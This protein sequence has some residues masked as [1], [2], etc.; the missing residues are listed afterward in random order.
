MNSTAVLRTETRGLS[1]RARQDESEPTPRIRIK[2][3]LF[4]RPPRLRLVSQNP[5]QPANGQSVGFAGSSA[6]TLAVPPTSDNRPRRFPVCPLRQYTYIN[7][8]PFAALISAPSWLPQFNSLITQ[9]VY[10]SISSVFLLL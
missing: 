5:L 9:S 6:R 3:Q 8:R 2:N 1:A 7:K 4:P 10:S